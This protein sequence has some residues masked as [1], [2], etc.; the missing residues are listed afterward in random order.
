MARHLHDAE[1]ADQ[2]RQEGHTSITGK[3]YTTKII[4]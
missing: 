2:L 1:I 3:P 4:Q